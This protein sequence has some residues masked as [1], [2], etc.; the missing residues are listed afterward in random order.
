MKKLSL[1]ILLTAGT[2]FSS[3]S[4]WLD[5]NHNPNSALKEEV[6]MDLLLSAVQNKMNRIWV[7]GNYTDNLSGSGSLSCLAQHFTKSGSYSGTYQ[8]L[9][10][11]IMPQNADTWWDY[12]YQLNANLKTVRDKAR[13]I[14][15]PGYDAIA[16]ALMVQ[17]FQMVV[18]I[19]NN[20]PYTES[21]LGG[22]N[23][24]P[25]YDKGPDIYT[26]LIQ[27]CEDAAANIDKALADPAYSTTK[28][29]TSD[30]NCH[31][32]LEQWKR[33]IYTIKLGLLMRIS[34]VQ[35]VAKQVDA[36]KDK[37]LNI[38]ENIKANPGYYK[39]TYKMN[40]IYELWGYSSLD[41]EKASHKEFR[42]TTAV[43]DFLRDN[44]D[45]RLRVYIQP[46][47][48]LGNSADGFADYIK[49]GLGDEY[50]IGV[51]FGQMSPPPHTYESGIGMG[52]LAGSSS[53]ITGP[54]QPSTI[55]TGA[56]VGF[57][58]AEAALRGMIAGGDAVARKYYED[59]VTSAIS[60]HETAM[61]DDGYTE[62][63][64][65]PAITIS[66]E[67][68]AKEYL[69]QNSDK[70]NWELM[71]TNDQKLEAICT[72]KWITLFC[73]NPLEAWSEQRRTDMPKLKR[74]V[75]ANGTKLICRLPYPQGERTL[76]PELVAAE[77][78]VN[79]Y[80]TRVFWDTKNDFV[81]ET[82]TYQ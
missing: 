6:S 29:K 11:L 65:L 71:K 31:G 3:C 36:I 69:A 60:R 44:N 32:D 15:D 78:D 14:D 82:P 40:P 55:K 54:T 72:Q 73:V 53:F 52:L 61:Q 75:S 38:D 49:H 51:P 22:T 48:N 30:I 77:G 33:Y 58:L 63:G 46:R 41:N 16:T 59:A 18:D 28:L 9:T 10:G 25:K 37:C 70:V 57:F 20:A 43:V 5:I 17:N 39:E 68:A 21:I 4:D 50:Y 35:D 79:V 23:T 34:N 27:E 81:P 76:N 56:E 66:G 42:P 64:T 2:V 80:E 13:E 47:K 1:Y 19:F 67:E 62:K 74:S 24:K 12:A 8:F 7:G 45:P 26:A